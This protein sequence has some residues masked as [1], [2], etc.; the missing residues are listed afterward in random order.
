MF[1]LTRAKTKDHP[2]IKK[3]LAVLD[4][5]CERPD[6][7]NFWVI[8]EH[9]RIVG[10]LKMDEF[11]EFIFLSSLGVSPDRQKRGIGGFALAE[12]SKLAQ[13]VNKPIFLYTIIPDFFKKSGFQIY[14]TSHFQLPTS[15]PITLPQKSPA[16]CRWCNPAKCITMVKFPNVAGL[17]KI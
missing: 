1:S 4:L 11:P 8:K 5:A 2:A 17:P 13:M 9:H 15:N 10:C 12:V 3:I 6:L 14:P 16:E 7:H